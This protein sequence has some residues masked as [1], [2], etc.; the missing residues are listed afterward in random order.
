[1]E[2]VIV[3]IDSEGIRLDHLLK[4][5]GLAMSGGQAGQFIIDGLIKVNGFLVSEKR[6]KVFLSDTI[7]FDDKYLIKLKAK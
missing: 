7:I 1:M 5:S 2:D 4:Y 6:K 3:E